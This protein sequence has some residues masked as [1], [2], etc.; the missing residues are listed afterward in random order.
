MAIREDLSDDDGS[1][2]SKDDVPQAN[3]K[4]EK[5]KK[6]KLVRLSSAIAHRKDRSIM[7]SARRWSGCFFL[8]SLEYRYFES[9]PIRGNA[10][11]FKARHKN[12]V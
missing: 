7:G 8:S 6:N 10:S 9:D 5:E 2:P 3:C 4:E 11:L 12:I 1:S